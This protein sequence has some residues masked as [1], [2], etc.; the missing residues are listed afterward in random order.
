[1]YLSDWCLEIVCV[2][3]TDHY[4]WWECTVLSLRQQP[5]CFHVSKQ[6]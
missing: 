1:M 4:S 6:L 3:G 2:G 5:S